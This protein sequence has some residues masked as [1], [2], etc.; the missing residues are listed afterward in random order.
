V[1][2][3]FESKCKGQGHSKDTRYCDLDFYIFTMVTTA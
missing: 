2:G 3:G 1:G